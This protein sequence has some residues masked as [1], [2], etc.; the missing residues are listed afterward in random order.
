MGR[1]ACYCLA[2]LLSS[3]VTGCGA[4]AGELG[5]GTTPPAQASADIPDGGPISPGP[6]IVRVH[7]DSPDPEL[8]LRGFGARRLQPLPDGRFRSLGP[9][10]SLCQAPCDKY[11]DARQGEPLLVAGPKTPPS[12]PFLL[13]TSAGDVLVSVEPGNKALLMTGLVTAVLGGLGGVVGGGVLMVGGISKSPSEVSSTPDNLMQ[14][15]GIAL[16]GSAAVIA[17]GIIMRYYGSTTVELGP[18]APSA[19]RSGALITF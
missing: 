1:T 17:A 7:L 19:Q 2:L 14:G 18:S 3:A 13:D 4:Q 12:T 10:P 9:S 16:G 15:G 6:G 8:E 11:V 5:P